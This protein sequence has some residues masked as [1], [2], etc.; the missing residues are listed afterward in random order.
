MKDLFYIIPN[1]IFLLGF[2]ILIHSMTAQNVELK[3]Q[4]LEH[5]QTQI[6]ENE[7]YI[8]S[9]DKQE[10]TAKKS[11]DQVQRKIKRNTRKLQQLFNQDKL[12]QTQMQQ[13][14]TDISTIEKAE[15]E[16]KNI[17]ISLYQTLYLI[18]KNSDRIDVNKDK[19]LM[20]KLLKSKLETLSSVKKDKE[21]LLE[22]AQQRSSA[23]SSIQKQ[24]KRNLTTASRYKQKLTTLDNELV[25][26]NRRR[27]DYQE[28]IDLLENEATSLKGLIENLRAANISDNFSYEFSSEEL[29]YPVQGTI[30]KSF[31]EHNFEENEKLKIWNNGIDFSVA[32]NSMVRAIDEG[33]VA[34]AAWF[35]GQGKVVIIDHQNGFHSLYSY[36]QS[37]LVSKGDTV[38]K[39]Q[40]IA[41]SGFD[42]KTNESILHFELRKRGKPVNPE[43]FFQ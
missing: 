5:L 16:Q 25:E 3:E 14:K 36:N 26:L 31:G 29:Q 12:L 37:L 35:K 1:K 10:E 32:E 39:D 19:F 6:E 27:L 20:A 17:C 34:F 4:K 2:L 41:H 7:I 13:T 21:K 22:I 23:Y 9:V 8:K 30:E 42:S 18:E 33:V 11:I 38:S 15:K 43:P 40:P 24:K 28:T